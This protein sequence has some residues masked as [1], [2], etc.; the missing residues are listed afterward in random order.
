MGFENSPCAVHIGCIL[1]CTSRRQHQRNGIILRCA[2]G[3][4][5]VQSTARTTEKNATIE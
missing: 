2:K 4:R 1:F 5:E 3:L